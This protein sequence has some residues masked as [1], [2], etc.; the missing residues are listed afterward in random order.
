MHTISLSGSRFSRS[1]LFQGLT[2][3]ELHDQV[4]QVAFGRVLYLVNGHDV[5]M[6]DRRCCACLAAKSLPGHVVLGQV[7]I[8]D[9]KRHVALQAGIERLQH[10]AHAPL[11]EHAHDIE[12]RDPA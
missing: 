2:R 10:N 6:A 7:R 8:K 1:R 4:G 11:S 3:H 9:L 5:L 12:V